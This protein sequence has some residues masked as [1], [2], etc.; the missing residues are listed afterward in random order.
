MKE[1]SVSGPMASGIGYLVFEPVENSYGV[2]NGLK[3]VK[4]TNRPPTVLDGNQRYIK[5]TVKVAQSVFD[6]LSTVVI[7]VPEADVQYPE[8]TV[9]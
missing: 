6:E 7:T 3:F 8:V 5:L 4:V 1:R 2:P 9:G